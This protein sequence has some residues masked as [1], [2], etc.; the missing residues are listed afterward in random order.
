L[1]D[2]WPTFG[3]DTLVSGLP[4]APRH[5]RRCPDRHWAAT[6]QLPRWRTHAR[7]S[8]DWHGVAAQLFEVHEGVS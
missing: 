3:I 5:R 6:R 4:I 1:T 7:R 8:G 2:T